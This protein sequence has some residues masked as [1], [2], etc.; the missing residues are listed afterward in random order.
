MKKN[1][2][3][4]LLFGVLAVFACGKQEKGTDKPGPID[5]EKE[6]TELYALGASV[7]KWDSMNPEPMTNVGKNLFSIEVDLVRS[8]ENKLIK[9]CTT[10]GKEWFET[11]YLVPASV[12]TDVQY[13]YLKEGENKIQH[14]S[15][16]ADGVGNL[17]DWFFGLDEGA[18]GHYRLTVNPLELT[19]IAEKLSDLEDKPEAVWK[20]GWVYMVGDATPAGWDISSPTEMVKD[21]DL[22]IYEGGLAAGDLKF[23]TEF[24]WDGPTYIAE[25]PGV[26]ITAGGEFNIVLAE[27]GQP[28]NKFKVTEPGTFKLT[29]DI[30][31][32]KLIVKNDNVQ[33]GD[34]PIEEEKEYTELY[35]LGASV[36]KWS[37][38]DPEPMTNVGK[39]LFCIEVDLIKSNE[40]KLIKFC[41]TSG[42]DWNE[43][44]YIVPAA[45]E[46]DKSYG[47]LKEGVE[48]KL[49]LTSEMAGGLKDWYF[50]LEAGASGRYRLTVNPSKLTVVAEKLSSLPDKSESVWREGWVYMVGDATPAAWA[51]ESPTEMTKDGDL[52]TFEGTLKAGELKFPVEFRWDGPTYL[53]ETAGTDITAGGEFNVVFSPNGNP[54]YKFKITKE[55]KYKLS[56]DTKSL[57]LKVELK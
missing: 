26:D 52:F 57:K 33:G 53:A 7:N 54:D 15:E 31:N 41:T 18:S 30:L 6:Y 1:S 55:G 38:N 48:N 27:E 39:N 21:G 36:N 5:I 47:Y 9:F 19:V 4:T 24:K 13:C 28:D 12:E 35:A 34:D 49:Q 56:L 14:S 11:D 16:K 45:V 46:Q 3:L 43:T 20:E 23:P 22:F 8:N 32:L 37:S 17:K 44:E 51:I 50:G 25:E 2:L 10:K 42:K 40:N 29:I